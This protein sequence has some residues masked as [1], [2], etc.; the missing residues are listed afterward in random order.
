M[1]YINGTTYSALTE[2]KPTISVLYLLFLLL[3]PLVVWSK[4]VEN[5]QKVS[6]ICD[7]S[8]SMFIHFEDYQLK[9][10]EIQN[11]IKGTT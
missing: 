7:L 3:N 11:K 10:D 5:P 4:N 6:V 9:Y 2:E 1:L 8:E